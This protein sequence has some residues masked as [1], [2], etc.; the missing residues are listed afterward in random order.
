[1]KN[2]PQRLA[3]GETLIG[4][5]LN[6]GS[7]LSTEM[8]GNAGFD[9]VVIDLEH[10]SGTESDVLHQLQALEHTV[11]RSV[12]RV[13]SHQRQRSHRVLDLGAHGIMFPRVN[14]AEEARAC[15][16][17]MR[18]PPEG[19]RGVASM[20]R[21][22][23]FGVTFRDYVEA[24]RDSLLGVLQIE[25]TEAVANVEEIAAVDGADVLFIGPLDLSISLGIL[26]QFDHPRF[27]EALEVTA[28]AARKHGKSTGVLMPKPDYFERF[29]GLGYRFLACGSDGA[30]VNNAARALHR[31]LTE[32]IPEPPTASPEA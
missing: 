11:T 7:P 16:A 8:V 2:M 27:Q 25:T 22:C 9:F 15:V 21:A 3:E 14:T 17:A 19:I 18:Y 29:H 6:L 32:L 10:G 26:G 24:S 4:C 30:M 20:N 31:T 5:F 12:I 23:E 1:M 28:A 13:E